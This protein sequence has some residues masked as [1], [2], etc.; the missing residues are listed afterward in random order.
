[1]KEIYVHSKIK[2]PNIVESGGDVLFVPHNGK[3]NIGFLV[4]RI[5]GYPLSKIIESTDI[6]NPAEGFDIRKRKLSNMIGAAQGL[7]HLANLGLVHRDVKPEN[8]LEDNNGN[9]LLCDLGIILNNF[10]TISTD[11]VLG[12]V[13][14]TPP[15]QM[16]GHDNVLLAAS[17]QFSLALTLQ[18]MIYGE[19]LTIRR[20]VEEIIPYMSRMV[21]TPNLY[22]YDMYRERDKN[23]GLTDLQSVALYLTWAISLNRNPFVRF[24]DNTTLA[25]LVSE[26]L[27]GNPEAIDMSIFAFMNRCTDPE[28]NKIIEDIRSSGI[29]LPEVSINQIN[30]S[31]SATK[32]ANLLN[33]KYH[34]SS[35]ALT[36]LPQ[37]ELKYNTEFDYG[38]SINK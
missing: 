19:T 2:H 28:N 12:T 7:D 30:N 10:D 4:Q 25:F 14:F 35:D 5:H 15:E 8:T 9:I 34:S 32:L 26:I 29:I 23:L 17:D 24:A 38:L 1:M 18:E 21:Y 27:D 16:L 33:N 22:N 6:D 13:V 31:R 20:E 11:K 36:H 37:G 3:Y